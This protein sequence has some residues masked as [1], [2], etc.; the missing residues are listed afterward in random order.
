[1]IVPVSVA[2]CWLLAAGLF[3]LAHQPAVAW[4]CVAVSPLALA[5]TLF[6]RRLKQRLAAIQYLT[7]AAR[8]LS[9]EDAAARLPELAPQGIEIDPADLPSWPMKLILLAGLGGV[10]AVAAAVATLLR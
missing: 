4:V 7:G 8:G 3:H 5:A 1:M 9:P 2:L 10:V 6:L